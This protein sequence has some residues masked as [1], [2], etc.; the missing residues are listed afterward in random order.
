MACFT[1][2]DR[3][4]N[5]RKIG[6]NVAY[7]KYNGEEIVPGLIDWT[8]AGHYLQDYKHVFTKEGFMLGNAIKKV[9]SALGIRQCMACKGRQRDY[10]EKGIAI[11]RKLKLI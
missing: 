10:N 6:E 8:C 7:V 2:R 9:T 5:E 3:N 4:G 11:Q 1:L